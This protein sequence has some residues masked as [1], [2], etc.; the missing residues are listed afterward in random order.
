MQFL[1][2]FIKR[3]KMDS[4]AVRHRPKKNLTV[5]STESVDRRLLLAREVRKL[6]HESLTLGMKLDV[7]D[8][9]RL[10]N[11]WWFALYSPLMKV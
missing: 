11:A 3:L 6:P 4:C 10:S 1:W 7:V 9:G 5:Q 8:A 2:L